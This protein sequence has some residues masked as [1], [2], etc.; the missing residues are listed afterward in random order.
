MGQQQLLLLVLTVIVVAIAVVLGTVVFGERFRAEQGDSLLNRNVHIAQEAINW[1]GRALI[2][3][4]GGG[5]S[6][7]PLATDGLQR[8][9]FEDA[10]ING[11]FAIASASGTTLEIVAVSTRF[12]GLG[13]YVRISGDEIDST[14]IRHDGSIALP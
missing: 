4:G 9:G 10:D 2:F 12:D 3:A 13:A 5:G 1:R 8:L 6:F 14:A 11:E 7:D